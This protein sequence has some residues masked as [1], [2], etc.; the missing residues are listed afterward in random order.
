MATNV[1]EIVQ[2]V[3]VSAYTLNAEI[4]V[5]GTWFAIT[6]AR[7]TVPNVLLVNRNVK[8]DVHTVNVLANVENLARNAKNRALGIVH[9]F[10]VTRNVGR[11]ARG[12]NVT[13]LALKQSLSVD[14]HALAFVKRNVRTFAEFV[15]RINWKKF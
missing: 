5:T 8:L 14:I 10:N 6:N 12:Q 2:I 11:F 13:I 15:T 4:N 9:I 7:V 1:L 3:I